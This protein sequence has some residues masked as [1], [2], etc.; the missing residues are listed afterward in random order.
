M[1]KCKQ[2]LLRH[3]QQVQD[4]ALVGPF[5]RM[6]RKEMGKHLRVS[7]SFTVNSTRLDYV[8]QRLKN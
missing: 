1:E 7:M 3:D 5:V 4:N 8:Q 2:P 6:N